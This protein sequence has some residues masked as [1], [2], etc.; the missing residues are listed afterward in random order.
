[1]ARRSSRLKEQVL[2]W[3]Q[4]LPFP[5][6][7]FPRQTFASS[8][9]YNKISYHLESLS[10][11]TH[12]LDRVFF[13]KARGIS[14]GRLSILR[15]IS[16]DFQNQQSDGFLQMSLLTWFISANSHQTP[17]IDSFASSHTLR[18]VKKSNRSICCMPE[19]LPT[20]LTSFSFGLKSLKRE[21][22]NKNIATKFRNFLRERLMLTNPLTPNPNPDPNPSFPS[23]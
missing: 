20:M 17:R 10:I 15:Q 21:N 13:K 14:C 23:L 2:T 1:M 5:T 7:A 4:L 11:H 12:R 3:K 9:N 16:R 8:W 19:S 18:E 6:H 22:K